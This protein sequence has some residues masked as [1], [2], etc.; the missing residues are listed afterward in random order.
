MGG[1]MKYSKSA[2]KKEYILEKARDVFAEKGFARVTMKD[3]VEACGISRGGL[4]L[5]FSCTK[6]IFLTLFQRENA[7]GQEAV[8]VAIWEKIPAPEILRSFIEAHKKQMMGQV[9]TLDH[10]TYEFFLENEEEQV[11]RRWQFDDMAE[12]IR[13]IL[14][15][16]IESGS[17]IAM[18][19]AAWGRHLA[20]CIN[21]LCLSMP[22]L[23]LPEERVDEE[24]DLLL[25]P[26]LAV[27]E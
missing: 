24:I 9:D 8:E 17:F 16:G 14:E 15:Y 2:Q 27:K 7:V 5:Y 26:I 4:Y 21:G 19:T 12:M 20:H 25:S 18:D 22:L 6:D 3:I 10:A 13:E 11:I 23:D 1:L